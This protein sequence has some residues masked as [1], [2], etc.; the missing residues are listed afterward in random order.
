[1]KVTTNHRFICGNCH[2][3]VNLLLIN[4]MTDSCPLC[5]V[6]LTRESIDAAQK[7]VSG[8]SLLVAFVCVIG[9]VW[10]IFK[11]VHNIHNED[12]FM[13]FSILFLFLTVVFGVSIASLVGFNNDQS[14]GAS[15]SSSTLKETRFC[16]ACGA[17]VPQKFRFCQ[18]LGWR[19]D[20]MVHRVFE[21]LNIRQ[22][23]ELD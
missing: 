23:K 13:K 20:R 5:G 4:R 2:R 17:T 12:D 1:M 14:K 7:T 11:I 21:P 3:D 18:F 15:K 9:M 6:H 19:C 16:N 22:S 10:S 8:N